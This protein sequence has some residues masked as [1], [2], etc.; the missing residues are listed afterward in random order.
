MKFKKCRV[1]FFQKEFEEF[2][3]QF[4]ELYIKDINELKNLNDENSQCFLKNIENLLK[5]QIGKKL[6][7]IERI[8]LSYSREGWGVFK[9]NPLENPFNI[10]YIIFSLYALFLLCFSG[11]TYHRHELLVSTP[12]REKVRLTI[13]KDKIEKKFIFVELAT[14]ETFSHFG[15]KCSITHTWNGVRIEK[16]YTVI[17]QE[18]NLKL[19]WEEVENGIFLLKIKQFQQNFFMLIDEIL[20][21]D[22]EKNYEI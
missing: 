17:D 4:L 15:L 14:T 22:L 1:V 10:N 9:E 20:D 12:Y 11:L 6:T 5:Q 7:K 3:E 16:T 2:A 8:K 18:K 19:F 13:F 21:D